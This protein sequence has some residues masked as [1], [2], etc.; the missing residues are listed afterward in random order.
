[1]GLQ[2]LASFGGAA[3]ALLIMQGQGSRCHAFQASFAFVGRQSSTN[4][5]LYA[6]DAKL[7]RIPA[8][9]DDDS[10]SKQDTPIPF[11]DPETNQ[12]IECYA[13]SVASVNGAEYTIGTPCDYA[14]ALCVSETDLDADEDEDDQ[15]LTPIELDEALMDEIFPVAESIVE[16]EFGEELVL[17]RTPQT[18]T[19]VGELD[20][21]AEDDEDDPED[22]LADE[23]EEVEIL[24]SFEH[25]RGDTKMEVHLVRLLDPVLLVGKVDPAEPGLNRRLLLT[26]DESDEIMPVLEGLF[27]QQGAQEGE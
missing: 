26:P 3:A 7:V 10:S 6:T 21:D 12:F 27:L 13:D 23:E 9:R 24:L 5:Q 19:L 15:S 11:V 22:D 2:Q 8:A 16:E 20:M 25:L 4:T 17:V 18:L 1:M 14:V